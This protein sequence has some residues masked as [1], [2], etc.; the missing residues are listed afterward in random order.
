MDGTVHT[1]VELDF[2]VD[3]EHHLPLEYVAVCYQATGDS[4]YV[5]V[6]LHL[7]ELPA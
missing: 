5:F 6:V 2:V 3:H 1:S 4:W 7:F